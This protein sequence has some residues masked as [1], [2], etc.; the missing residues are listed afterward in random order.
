MAKYKLMYFAQHTGNIANVISIIPL[1]VEYYFFIKRT[2]Q[3]RGYRII[4][5]SILQFAP[6]GRR[7]WF[8]I[9]EK[10][11]EMDGQLH[12]LCATRPRALQPLERK[13]NW[14][15]RRTLSIREN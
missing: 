10:W 4:W 1:E 14:K 5:A 6:D 8:A 2:G 13:R 12:C 9:L 11:A 7:G 15:I 3:I